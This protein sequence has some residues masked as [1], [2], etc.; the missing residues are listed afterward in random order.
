M[1]RKLRELIPEFDQI[2]DVTLRKRVLKTWD[3]AIKLGGW[4]VEDLTRIPFAFSIQDCQISIVEH[5]RGVTRFCIEA[6]KVLKETYGNKIRIKRDYL[7]AGAL[8]HDIGKLLETKEERGRFV[9]S[10]SGSLIRHPF[11]G[12][13]LCYKHGIPDE[14]L[15]IVAVH[16]KEGDSVERTPEAK[17]LHHADFANFEIFIP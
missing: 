1:R 15:H 13:A 5:V 17:I 11:S 12:V 9:K 14:I 6:E 10:R 4:S 2:E 8:L 16:S 3:E 7:I